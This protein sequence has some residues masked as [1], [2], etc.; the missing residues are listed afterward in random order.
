MA[1]IRLNPE[2]S[3]AEV[4]TPE[5]DIFIDEIDSEDPI[6]ICS[7][8]DDAGKPCYVASVGPNAWGLEVNAVYKLVKVDTEI[9][10]NCEDVELE[11][12]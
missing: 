6:M 5:G 4:L 2:G 11:A 7:D 8:D 9:E 12:D 10:L 3:V 1:K